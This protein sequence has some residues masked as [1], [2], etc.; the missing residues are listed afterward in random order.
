MRE[1]IVQAGSFLFGRTC[2]KR[3]EIDE[4]GQR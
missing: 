4:R 3:I 2:R 1:K